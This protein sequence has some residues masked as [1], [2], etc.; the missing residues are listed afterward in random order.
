MPDKD[1]SRDTQVVMVRAVAR[2]WIRKMAKAEYRVR[3]FY[4]SRGY[5]NLPNLLR[6]FRDGKTSITGVDRIADLGVDPDEG[7]DSL[8]VWSHDRRG[9]V[10]LGQWLED[11]G[12][13]TTGV[14]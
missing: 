13:D 7:G 14:W 2:R 1:D 9:M 11:K 6:A 12:F 3:V 5:Q 10:K 8:E 4:G